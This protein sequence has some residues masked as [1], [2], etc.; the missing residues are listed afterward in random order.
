MP[1][2]Q[3]YIDAVTSIQLGNA[4][5]AQSVKPL[6]CSVPTSEEPSEFFL[7]EYVEACKKAS[8]N[9]SNNAQPQNPFID[10]AAFYPSKESGMQPKPM[11][12]SCEILT[13]NNPQDLARFNL[14]LNARSNPQS[15]IEVKVMDKQYNQELKT[16]QIFVIY[17][18]MSPL[19]LIK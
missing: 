10:N 1:D 19:N 15:K 11:N 7:G 17:D 14:L 16:W 2:D 9:S 4:K 8:K 3:K 5:N 18:T 6:G 13:L 12:T